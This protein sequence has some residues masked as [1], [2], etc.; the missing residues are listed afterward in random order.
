MT[1]KALVDYSRAIAIK[2]KFMT[3]QVSPR[4]IPADLQQFI[5]AVLKDPRLQDQLKA[6][7]DRESLVELAVQLGRAKGYSFT[8]EDLEATM[9][10]QNLS[11]KHLKIDSLTEQPLIPS[12]AI[13]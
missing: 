1:G 5:Q 9:V 3:Q 2:I 10:Q 6:A 8:S 11:A 13:W 4:T 12:K 7:P